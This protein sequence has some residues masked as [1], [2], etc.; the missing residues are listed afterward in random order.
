MEERTMATK[1]RIVHLLAVFCL[2]VLT[3]VL[4]ARVSSAAGSAPVTVVNTASSPV[5]VSVQGTGSITGSVTVTNPASNPVPV[6]GTVTISPSTT[7][8]G[9]PVSQ[10]VSLICNANE[11]CLGAKFA[12][13]TVPD[14]KALVITDFRFKC[15][16]LNT[17]GT[18]N[19]VEL[20]V[21]AT[22]GDNQVPFIQSFALADPNSFIAG[23]DHLTTGLVAAPGAV[24][25]IACDDSRGSSGGYVQGY[26]VPN[27]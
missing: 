9:Q 27:Q 13:F 4:T 1:K 21:S 12:Q 10:L 22:L 7:H 5:P 16:G 3:V 8:V 15:Q 26:L 17:P 14:G 24:V 23:L 18:Y 11:P 25:T 20:K 2:S 19:N 6:T